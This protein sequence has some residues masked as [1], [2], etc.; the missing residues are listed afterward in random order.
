MHDFVSQLHR[1]HIYTTT[2]LSLWTVH[3]LFVVRWPYKGVAGT[4]EKQSPFLWNPLSHTRHRNKIQCSCIQAIQV[5]TFIGQQLRSLSYIDV[6]NWNVLKVAVTH[7]ICHMNIYITI[8]WL[9]CDVESFHMHVDVTNCYVTI[10]AFQEMTT[11][12][13]SFYGHHTC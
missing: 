3:L 7:R 13:H 9:D 10:E 4:I 5:Y 11:T 1:Y 6:T 8:S 2:S 12:S